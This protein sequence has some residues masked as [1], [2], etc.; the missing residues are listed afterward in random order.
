[1]KRAAIFLVLLFPALG[2]A[3][4]VAAHQPGAVRNL[5]VA[6]ALALVAAQLTNAGAAAQSHAHALH[7]AVALGCWVAAICLALRWR[8]SG[9]QSCVRS[10]ALAKE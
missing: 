9:R 5:R 7:A 8:R 1:M 10:V 3:A 6:L 2:L 4:V